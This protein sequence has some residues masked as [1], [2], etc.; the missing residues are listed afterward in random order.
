M[1]SAF[2]ALT[3][4]DTYNAELYQQTLAKALAHH[5]DAKLLLLD[6]T[7]FTLKVLC[8]A[9]FYRTLA[10]LLLI[11]VFILFHGQS[12][13]MQS[14]YGIFKKESVSTNFYYL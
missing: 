10:Y 12:L 2:S 8:K 9:S 14:K 3:M 4:L 5:F 13:Q 1:L 7:D 11:L 6:L